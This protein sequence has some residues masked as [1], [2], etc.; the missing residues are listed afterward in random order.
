MRVLAEKTTPLLALSEGEIAALT[1]SMWKIGVGTPGGAEALVFFHQLLHDE[2]M[3]G[4]LSG[5][6]A[7]ARGGVAVLPKAH[8]SSENIEICL[9]LNKK[10]SHQCRGI[11]VQSKGDVDGPVECTW[12]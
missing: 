9:M 8:S 1:T 4:S 3:T 7:S 12:P 11:E 10:G 2:W 6:L 5:Q